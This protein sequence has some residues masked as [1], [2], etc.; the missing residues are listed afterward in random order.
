MN[1]SIQKVYEWSSRQTAED[2]KFNLEE[3]YWTKPVKTALFRLK[4]TERILIRIQGLQGTGKSA[5]LRALENSLENVILW[6]WRRDWEKS[7]FDEV[8][9]WDEYWERLWLTAAD[10]LEI[11]KKLGIGD[12]ITM[13]LE[14]NV[15]KNASDEPHPTETDRFGAPMTHKE[16]RKAML[17]ERADS[18]TLE[19]ALGPNVVQSIKR[20]F[21]EGYLSQTKA[22]LIDMPDYNKTNLQLMSKDIDELQRMWN[23]FMESPWRKTSFVV[24]VQKEIV[25]RKPHYFF[26]KMQSIELEPLTAEQ[27]LEAY[28]QRWQSFEPFTEDA[29][30]FIAKLSRGV[31]RRFLKYINLTIEGFMADA[32]STLISTQDVE[33]AI[34]SKTLL[35]DMEL[36][37]SDIFSNSQHRIQAVKLFEMLRNGS[38][39]Q[40]QIAE[41]LGISEATAGKLVGKLQTYDYVKRVRGKGASLEVSLI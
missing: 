41:N 19:K 35:D 18:E 31:F 7:F 24:S 8:T 3:Y 33:K 14:L 10:N 22:I 36:E 30:R 15:W 29:L 23:Y 5:A 37:L 34:S 1:E 13:R 12:P 9:V 40:K 20:G 6:K 26:G 38:L 16:V 28:L 25:M 4:N 27:L 2:H 21:L 17:D 39:T 11:R 32:K